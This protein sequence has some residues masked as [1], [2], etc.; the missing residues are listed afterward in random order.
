MKCGV[1]QLKQ[2]DSDFESGVKKYENLLPDGKIKD[3]LANKL[4]P[5]GREYLDSVEKEFVPVMLN[6]DTKKGVELLTTDIRQKF[7]A[8]RASCGRV[9]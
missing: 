7:A 8:H 4:Y 3:L 9:G 6:L 5:S 1:A 2:Q